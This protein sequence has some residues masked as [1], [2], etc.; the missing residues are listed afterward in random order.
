MKKRSENCW[1][2]YVLKRTMRLYLMILVRHKLSVMTWDNQLCTSSGFVT[3]G[4]SQKN[5]KKVKLVRAVVYVFKGHR[6]RDLE[7]L[8]KLYSRWNDNKLQNILPWLLDI[9]FSS[10]F[11]A[12]LNIVVRNKTKQTSR[13]IDLKGVLDLKFLIRP[14]LISI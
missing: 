1:D 2:N 8:S 10:A 13:N 3:V 5:V 14:F 12:L 7:V 6:K 11:D 4:P 9:I